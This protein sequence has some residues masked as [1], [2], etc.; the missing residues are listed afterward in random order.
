VADFETPAY[1]V[2]LYLLTMLDSRDRIMLF[3]YA[4]QWIRWYDAL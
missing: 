2:K 4:I 3:S 1:C